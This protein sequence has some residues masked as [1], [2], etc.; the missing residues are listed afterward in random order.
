MSRNAKKVKKVVFKFILFAFLGYVIFLFIDQFIKIKNKS[1]ELSN[2]EQK[3]AL[4]EEKNLEMKQ[5]LESKSG[6]AENS[7]GNF[8]S[9]KSETIVFENVT[10]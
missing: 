4:E 8:G 7:G 6:D 5:E 10:E 9:K 3:I 2:V 1:E